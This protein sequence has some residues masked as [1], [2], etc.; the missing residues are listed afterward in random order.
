MPSPQGVNAAIPSALAGSPPVPR[1]VLASL[2]LSDPG[3]VLTAVAERLGALTG[4]PVRAIER[5]DAPAEALAAL[6]GPAGAWLA[7]LPLDVGVVQRQGSWAEAL[8]AWRQPTVL[9]LEA[10]Q[11]S[12]GLPAA[13]TALLRHWQVPLVGL[14]GWGD[15][16]GTPQDPSAA[17]WNPELELS[18]QPGLFRQLDQGPGQGDGLPWLG[19]LV[20]DP[21][22]HPERDQE[23][24]LTLRAG[25]L[26]QIGRLR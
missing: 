19:S 24:L 2:A 20:S 25:W 26:E 23:L 7:P 22:A 12:S 8:G 4:L 1:L 16:Q 21:A 6:T 10:S 18:G 17:S 3:V 15:N 14:L 9:V 5:A 11:L 13:A